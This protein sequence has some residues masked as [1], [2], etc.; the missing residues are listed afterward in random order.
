M[1]KKCLRL[2]LAFGGR[3]DGDGEAEDIFGVLV[4]GLGEYGVFFE[5]YR[6]VAHLI[7]SGYLDTAK[8]F[9]ARQDDVDELIEE[10]LHATPSQRDLVADDVARAALEISD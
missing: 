3:D 4:G 9:D 7:D 2:F 8:V 5:P 1:A 10:R 6:D